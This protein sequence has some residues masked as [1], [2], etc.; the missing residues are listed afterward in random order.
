MKLPSIKIAMENHG[1]PLRKNCIPPVLSFENSARHP[2]RHIPRHTPRFL[3]HVGHETIYAS[4]GNK[5]F[6]NK[7]Y[8]L[9]IYQNYEQPPRTFQNSDFQS[10]FSVLKIGRILSN[11]FL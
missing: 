3:D 10:H 9:Q 8:H 11:V 4:S 5:H 2:A 7:S 6:C 1:V